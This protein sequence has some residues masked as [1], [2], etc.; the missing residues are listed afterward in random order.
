MKKYILIAINTALVITAVTT[1]VSGLYAVNPG[2]F[3]YALEFVGM[4]PQDVT[5]FA[6]NM[7]IVTGLGIISKS[8]N[9]SIK[10][11]NLS[12]KY[13]YEKEL[14]N[15]D[16]VFQ[17]KLEVLER[18]LSEK[19]TRDLLQFAKLDKTIAKFDNSIDKLIQYEEVRSEHQIS[20]P[21]S[22]V[23]PEVKARYKEL[24]GK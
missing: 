18:K 11:E 7:G 16:A 13:Y 21:D 17:K 24:R 12:I 8:V 22:I 4:T 6:Q 19:E 9:M 23:K 3:N 5:T 2:L 20:L 14:K 10:K 1:A 15:Q